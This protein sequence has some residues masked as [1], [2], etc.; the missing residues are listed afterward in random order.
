MGSSA[1]KAWAALLKDVQDVVQH[2]GADACA[3]VP[4]GCSDAVLAAAALAAAQQLLQSDSATV[5]KIQEQVMKLAQQ[6]SFP[7]A[8][9]K[10]LINNLKVSC[11]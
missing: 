7:R 9:W 1:E 10:R 8:I 4:A 2:A 6:P 11:A 3:V 5:F